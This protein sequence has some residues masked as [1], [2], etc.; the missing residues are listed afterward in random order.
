MG[1]DRQKYTQK[2]NSSLLYGNDTI[3]SIAIAHN[4]AIHRT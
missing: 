3:K 2:M 1:I 4:E